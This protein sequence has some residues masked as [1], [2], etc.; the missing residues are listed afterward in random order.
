[1]KP[2]KYHDCGHRP[3]IHDKRKRIDTFRHS[4]KAPEATPD[5]PPLI[6]SMQAILHTKEAINLTTSQY[7][8]IEVSHEDGNL[9]ARA[10][11]HDKIS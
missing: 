7:L 10:G 3:R 9:I 1:M 8:K 5:A 11:I 2:D 6:K 4:E